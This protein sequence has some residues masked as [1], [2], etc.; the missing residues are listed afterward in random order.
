M[1][2]PEPLKVKVGPELSSKHFERP[3]VRETDSRP[4][5]NIHSRG[6]SSNGHSRSLHS[7]R[8]WRR[9]RHAGIHMC[10][11]GLEGGGGK[12]ITKGVCSL[13]SRSM[14]I[15][16]RG[17]QMEQGSRNTKRS[18]RKPDVVSSYRP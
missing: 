18:E 12:N 13:D 5:V 3:A 17:G 7:E 10:L 4:N 2:L 6:F 9:G 16:L 8:E 1:F 15:L 11:N 14:K